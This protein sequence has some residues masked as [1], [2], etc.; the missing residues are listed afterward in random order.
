MTLLSEI[1]LHVDKEDQE[2]LVVVK[3]IQM[4]KQIIARQKSNEYS[5]IFIISFSTQLG[6]I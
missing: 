6:N 3:T 5:Y 2:I 1:Y 4:I